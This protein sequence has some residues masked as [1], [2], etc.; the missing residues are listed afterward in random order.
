M[1]DRIRSQHGNVIA[2]DFRPSN[3]YGLSLTLRTTVLYQDASVVLVRTAITDRDRPV[4]VSHVLGDLA[5]G[6]VTTL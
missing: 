6:H 5:T 2:A 1:T 3:E 4:A